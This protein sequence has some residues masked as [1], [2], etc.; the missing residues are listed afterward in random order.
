MYIEE[1]GAGDGDIK[2][3]VEGEEYTGEANHDLD[4][5]GIDETIAVMTDDGFVAYVDEDADGDADLMQTI[6]GSGAV[7]DQA[8]F[9]ES[10]GDW[11]AEE[12]GQQP[13]APDPR[14]DDPAAA[15]LVDTP[16]GERDLGPATEDTDGDGLADTAVV[17]RD[18]STMLVTDLDGDGSADQVVQ[19][20]HSGEVTVSEHS[21]PGQ[22]TVVE[23]G[24]LGPDG[25][26]VPHPASGPTGTDD[27]TWTFDEEPATP[28]VAPGL[29]HASPEADA[30]AD[31][32]WG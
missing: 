16:E 6:A 3:T 20:G 4:G 26:Y 30:D 8:R 29:G 18:N 27:A 14:P 19:L 25:A 5:D 32:V 24:H 12:P 31:S 21:G 2:V 23:E 28:I 7:V 13:P 11:V 22:W 1:T 10:S 15:M 9:D 17:D